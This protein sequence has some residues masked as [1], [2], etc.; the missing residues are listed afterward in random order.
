METTDKRHIPVKPIPVKP[1]DFSS[2]QK[3]L[4]IRLRTDLMEQNQEKTE[5][6]QP[7]TISKPLSSPETTNVSP[8]PKKIRKKKKK[9]QIQD[10]GYYDD[11]QIIKELS[12]K[13]KSIST[14]IKDGSNGS[15]TFKSNAAEFIYD[16]LIRTYGNVRTS[17]EQ[18]NAFP[19]PNITICPICKQTFWNSVEY[20][21]HMKAK[22]PEANQNQGEQQKMCK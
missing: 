20:T 4:L 15:T 1:S 13:R 9:K 2:F 18:S 14:K 5:K 8:K 16:N 10:V 22:H 11:L 19:I 17:T 12:P 3:R 6:T 21:E 7:E